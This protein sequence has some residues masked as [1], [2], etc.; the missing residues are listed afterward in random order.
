MREGASETRDGGVRLTTPKP[1]LTPKDD[2]T[3]SEP[4]HTI[5]GGESQD[6]RTKQVCVL[7]YA[8][9]QQGELETL[10]GLETLPQNC[11][12]QY[13]QPHSRCAFV[14]LHPALRQNLNWG[15]SFSIPRLVSGRHMYVCTHGSTPARSFCCVPCNNLRILSTCG[16]QQ[17]FS[18]RLDSKN[19][20][21]SQLGLGPPARSPWAWSLL[22][23]LGL[24]GPQP[25]PGCHVMPSGGCDGDGRKTTEVAG[26]GW[27]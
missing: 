2:E 5:F 22:R 14:C 13:Q 18:T 11:C 23:C 9:R 20:A 15:R 21:N 8:V 1:G 19:L 6:H 10:V 4:R 3:A 27:I 26:E 16:C 12:V 17:E 7:M 25:G 24:V